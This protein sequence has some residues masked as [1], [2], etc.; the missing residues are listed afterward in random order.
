M[1]VFLTITD[2]SGAAQGKLQVL[3]LQWPSDPASQ[4]W[5]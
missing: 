2:Q 5:E 3:L 4:N 1:V